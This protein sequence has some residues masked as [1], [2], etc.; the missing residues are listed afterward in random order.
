MKYKV[1][2]GKHKES[3]A[4]CI[5]GK[6]KRAEFKQ[7]NPN[8]YAPLEAVSTETAGPLSEADISGNKYLQMIVDA[9]TGWTFGQPMKTKDEATYVLH[10]AL[11]TAGKATACMLSPSQNA[12]QGWRK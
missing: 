5:K 9:G 3:C 10:E 1:N 8:R 12:S 2:K 7:Q 4:P 11:A 6:A